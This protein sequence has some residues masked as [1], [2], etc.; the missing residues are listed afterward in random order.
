MY[1]PQ[2]SV[3]A[4]SMA[5]VTKERFEQVDSLMWLKQLAGER[6]TSNT[7][8]NYNTQKKVFPFSQDLKMQTISQKKKYFDSSTTAVAWILMFQY[9]ASSTCVYSSQ[10]PLSSHIIVTVNSLLM[11]IEKQL[12]I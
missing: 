2:N 3:L 6:N 4:K 8:N 5:G 11:D 7:Q 10:K 12:M 9:E 1:G